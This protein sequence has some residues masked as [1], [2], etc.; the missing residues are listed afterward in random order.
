MT[1]SRIILIPLPRGWAVYFRKWAVDTCFRKA[2]AERLPFSRIMMVGFL[3]Q[4]FT[5]MEV[6]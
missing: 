4:C 2:I 1:E 6:P 3:P 5:Q